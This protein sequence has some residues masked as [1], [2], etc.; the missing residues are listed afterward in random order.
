MTI[1]TVDDLA[2]EIL[3]WVGC[4]G[5]CKHIEDGDGCTDPNP[6]CC[7]IGAMLTLPDRIRKAVENDNILDALTEKQ[8]R[9][10]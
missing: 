1:E 7:R 3:N 9:Q 5:G 4:W 10:I 8:N 6:F 2:N